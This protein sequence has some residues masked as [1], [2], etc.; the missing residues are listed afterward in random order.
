MPEQIAYQC[1]NCQ[2]QKLSPPKT[3]PECCGQPMQNIPMDQCT[4]S[5]TAEHSRWDK[6][7][8][9]CDDGRAG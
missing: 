9:P 6:D 5:T 2:S 1:D 4:L 8:E 7:D 3:P